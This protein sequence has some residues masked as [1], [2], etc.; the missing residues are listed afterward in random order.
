MAADLRRW[1]NAAELL[2]HLGIAEPQD[3]DLRA[4]AQYCGATIV[5]EPLRGSVARLTARGER[6][7]I[8]VDPSAPYHR[9]RFSAAHELADW[10]LDRDRQTFVC[11]QTMLLTGQGPAGSGPYR[12]NLEQRANR[13]AADLPMPER[14][15]A[16]R[17][18]D[19]PFTF[20]TARDLARTFST[21][22][23]GSA[24]RM[25]RFSEPYP[26]MLIWSRLGE[27]FRWFQ[28]S[29]G[30]PLAAWPLAE[31]GEGSLAHR[32]LR[33]LPAER[34]PQDVKWK[35]WFALE[36]PPLYYVME[37]SLRLR[38]SEVL[39]LV[40]FVDDVPLLDLESEQPPHRRGF[41]GDGE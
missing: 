16:P 11:T 32:L 17:V 33:G 12:G 1:P 30:M 39:S 22:L 38:S 18:A 5:F 7:L 25:V 29:P 36:D 28:R 14:L 37:D 4:I 23:I 6:A 40:L 31:P 19:C 2:H 15:F 13:W 21:G 20:D 35:Y 27:R 26:S 9:Q 41:V 24:R 10:M 8:T 3:I 34:G